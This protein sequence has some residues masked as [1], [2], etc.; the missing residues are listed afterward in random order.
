MT[1]LIVNTDGASR[2]NPGEA[3]VGLVIKDETDKLIFQGGRYLGKATNNEAEY[4]AVIKVLEILKS[5]FAQYLP[6]EVE[7]RAD[8]QLIVRQLSGNYKVKNPRLKVLFDQVKYLETEVGRIYY[9]QI[10]RAENALADKQA[11][12][13]LDKTSNVEE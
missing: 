12:I 8:S 3:A 11:N 1:K 10:P 2:G 6:A 13:V 9:R 4:L 5:D 7:I